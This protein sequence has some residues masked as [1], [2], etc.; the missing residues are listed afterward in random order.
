MSPLETLY[1]G[2][3]LLDSDDIR[4]ISILPHID[5]NSFITCDMR[6][7]PTST[8]YHALS[9]TWGPAYENDPAKPGKILVNRVLVGVTANLLS[10]MKSLRLPDRPRVLWVSCMIVLLEIGPSLTLA[11]DVSVEMNLARI[12]SGQCTDFNRRCLIH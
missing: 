10:A 4:L 2:L 9:Y 8:P 5:V 7:C 6:V 11:A 12:N 1:H 3:P